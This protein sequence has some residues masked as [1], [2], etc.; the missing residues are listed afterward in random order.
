LASLTLTI[1]STP[2]KPSAKT[3]QSPEGAP[4]LKGTNATKYP[5][6]GYGARFVDP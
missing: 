6:W 3:S 4:F 1:G 2:A 5:A